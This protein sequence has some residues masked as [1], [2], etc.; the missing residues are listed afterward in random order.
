MAIVTSAGFWSDSYTPKVNRSPKLR[1]LER[2]RQPLAARKDAELLIEN[3]GVAVGQTA[4]VTVKQVKHNEAPGT[5]PV[6]GVVETRTVISR[7]TVAADETS[8]EARLATNFSRPTY[9]ADLSGNGGG[10]KLQAS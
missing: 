10:S 3:I 1:Q 5:F 6:Q 9:A 7:A 8:Q 4:S 2:M